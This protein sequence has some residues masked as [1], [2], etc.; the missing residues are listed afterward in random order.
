MKLT[1]HIIQ[2]DLRGHRWSLVFWLLLFVVQVAFGVFMLHFDHPNLVGSLALMEPALVFWSAGPS[3]QDLMRRTGSAFQRYRDGDP[4]GAARAFYDAVFEPDYRELLDRTLPAGWWAETV[5][6]AD[7]FFQAELPGSRPWQFG[8]AEA[9]RITA[10]VLS[11][12]GTL[13]HPA[14]LEWEQ[15]LRDWFPRLETARIPGAD[16]LLQLRQP[17][18]VAAAMAEFLAKHPL[19]G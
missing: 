8:Q 18:L 15:L 16:H 19:S 1:W 5:R 6:V 4:E 3:I 7:W 14:R 2:K 10:P 17:D 11:M 13:S 12:V 9:E